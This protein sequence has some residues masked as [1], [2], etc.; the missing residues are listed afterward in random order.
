MTGRHV[1][2]RLA[3]GVG[4]EDRSNEGA[5]SDGLDGFVN[6]KVSVQGAY[7]STPAAAAALSSRWR[8]QREHVRSASRPPCPRQTVC[9]RRDK[10][11]C[12]F[13]SIL[14]EKWHSNDAA[15]ALLLFV[16]KRCYNV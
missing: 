9:E 5:M 3:K 10:R 1:V 8:L 14:S 12:R 13:R 4:R 7:T 6:E 16:G 11:V 2:A 15:S